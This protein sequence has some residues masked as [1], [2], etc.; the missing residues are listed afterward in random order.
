MVEHPP[1]D[2]WIGASLLR[3]EDARHL[4]GHGMFIADVRVPGVQDIAFVRSQRAHAI[5]RQIIKPGDLAANVFTLE[6]IG[7]LSI[8]EAGTGTRGPPAQPLSGARRRPGPLRGTGDRGVHAAHRALAEDL[9]D[10]VSRSISRNCR[11]S[12]I[13]F[14]PCGR[15]ARACSTTWPDNAY[16]ASTVE[17]GNPVA[18]VVGADPTAPAV[19]HE[20]AGHGLARMPRRA[21]LLGPP[22][23][24]T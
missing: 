22:Q 24:R 6:D 9:A 20:P 17:E 11:R 1:A 7:P 12:S 23:R 8:L 15:T 5:V 4:L 18:A 10:R 2:G 14:P 13:A 21:R 3:K 19:P 16:I